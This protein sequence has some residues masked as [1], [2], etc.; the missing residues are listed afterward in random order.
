MVDL[1]ANIHIVQVLIFGIIT[2]VILT[3]R[4]AVYNTTKAQKNITD[5]VL[6]EEEIK[7]DDYKIFSEKQMEW[8]NKALEGAEYDGIE[9]DPNDGFDAEKMTQDFFDLFD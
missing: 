7:I 2:G 5:S 3:F 4:V 8:A 1:L 9:R 6:N